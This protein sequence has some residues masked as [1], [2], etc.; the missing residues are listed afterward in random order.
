MKSAEHNQQVAVFG[1]AHWQERKHPELKLLFAIPNAGKRT[2]RQGAWLKAEGLKAGIPDICLPV[3]RGEYIG[4]WIELKAIKNK[5]TVSQLEWIDNLRG[6]GHCVEVCYGWEAA[7]D[8][9]LE[10]LGTKHG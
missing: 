7:R 9:I 6:A 8:A 2:A 5:P 3:K 1:W 4:L 10:Y